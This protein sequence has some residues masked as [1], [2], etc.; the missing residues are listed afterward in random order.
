MNNDELQKAID[1]ITRDNAAPVT[2]TSGENEALA[3]E[4]AGAAAEAAPVSPAT[5][6]VEAGGVDAAA[7]FNVPAAPAPVVPEM[8][9]MPPVAPSADPVA[10]E[11]K[12]VVAAPAPA[13]VAPVATIQMAH[14]ETTGD[15]EAI[16]KEALKALYPLLD[17]VE[18]KPEEKF[19]IW[20][21]VEDTVALGKALEY[22]KQFADETAKANALLKIV[23]AAK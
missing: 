14:A 3:N 12:P 13:E 22:A 23:D 15:K 6:A 4:L 20:M 17:K 10:A 18:L 7:D 11:P 16:E 21:K 5:P 9:G 8:P 1:D 19:E 2:E